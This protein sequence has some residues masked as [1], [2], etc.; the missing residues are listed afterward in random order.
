MKAQ[1]HCSKK[2]KKWI[3]TKCLH[4][5]L[6]VLLRLQLV[7]SS[8]R[9]GGRLWRWSETCSVWRFYT[10]S[11]WAIINHRCLQLIQPPVWS[12]W[13]CWPRKKSEEEESISFLK[14][15]IQTFQTNRHDFARLFVIHI[16]LPIMF[17]CHLW[18]GSA[19]GI[20]LPFYP[21]SPLQ[22]LHQRL[23]VLLN[24]E[25]KKKSLCWHDVK[26]KLFDLFT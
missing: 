4:E 13:F 18:R 21:L 26:F 8:K 25:K 24:L 19:L 12:E 9:H 22:T 23:R 2:T 3:L 15:M 6:K 10:N 17:S 7:L 20:D 1:Q 16:F 14:L 5:R 11:Y